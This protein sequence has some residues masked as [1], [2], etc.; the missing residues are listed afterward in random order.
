MQGLT[1]I[2]ANL[3]HL[4]PSLGWKRIPRFKINIFG[5][6]TWKMKGVQKAFGFQ[7]SLLIGLERKRDR[8]SGSVQVRG[9]EDVSHRPKEVADQ[10]ELLLC[11]RWWSPGVHDD[12]FE[13]GE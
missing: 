13:A 3:H 12:C 6:A 9:H 1:P 7:A 5:V 4:T 10:G 8:L 2:E 11:L